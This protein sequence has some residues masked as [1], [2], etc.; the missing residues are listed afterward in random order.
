MLVHSSNCLRRGREKENY[1]FRNKPQ[2]LLTFETKTNSLVYI[3][4][5]I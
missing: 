2:E 5:K 4:N 1:V 3:Q